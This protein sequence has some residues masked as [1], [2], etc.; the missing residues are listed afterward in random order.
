[1]K[2]FVYF[3]LALGRE[4]TAVKI[5]YTNSSPHKRLKSLQT[6]SSAELMLVAVIEGDV[7]L[8]RA[9]H[10]TFNAVHSRGEWFL[11]SGRLFSLVA[12]LHASTDRGSKPIGVATFRAVCDKYLFDPVPLVIAEGED[13]E[14]WHLTADVGHLMQWFELRG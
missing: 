14:R 7:S 4:R 6:G 3:I 2:G 9:L 11:L 10:A 5:G 12:A 1:M 13:D 8:E